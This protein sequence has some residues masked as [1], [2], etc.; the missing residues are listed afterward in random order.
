MD[1][2]QFAQI[3]PSYI[4][5]NKTVKRGRR[6]SAA[7]AVPEPSVMDM[8]HALQLMGV[9]HAVQ[10]Y[11]GYSRDPES[12][13]DNPGRVLVDLQ[14]GNQNDAVT[15]GSDGAFDIDDEVPNIVED[16]KEGTAWK[17]K[18]LLRE[19]ATRLKK[20]PARVQRLEQKEKEEEATAQKVI[21]DAAAAHK[22][23]SQKASTAGTSGK[24]KKGKKKR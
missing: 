15:I 5:S 22:A 13:W 23:A 8:T 18:H 12:Q 6:I 16:G 11:K 3:Y 14:I 24:K 2:K 1:Y 10:P 19:I 7:D 20:L 17:K 21:E 9:R 4:D